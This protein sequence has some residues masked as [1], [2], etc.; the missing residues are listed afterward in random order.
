MNRQRCFYWYIT[1]SIYERT[2]GWNGK[3][4]ETGVYHLDNSSLILVDYISCIGIT[5]SGVQRMWNTYA[6]CACW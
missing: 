3:K 2:V 4:S 5:P 6:K 1:L